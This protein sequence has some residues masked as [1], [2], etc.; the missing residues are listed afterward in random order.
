[1]RLKRQRQYLKAARTASI[2]SFKNRKLDASS[3][4][5]LAQLQTDEDKFSKDD[6]SDKEGESGIWFWNESANETDSDSEEEGKL[7]ERNWERKQS[8]AQQ[9]VSLKASKVEIR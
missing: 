9:E 4:P 8:S 7:D 3:L 6:T 1:M 2:E 5:K